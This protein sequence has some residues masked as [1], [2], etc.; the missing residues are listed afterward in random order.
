MATNKASKS[1][2]LFAE[3]LIMGNAQALLTYIRYHIGNKP[4]SQLL[5]IMKQ[6]RDQLNLLLPPEE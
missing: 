3:I 5:R 6:L 2:P 4:S 1:I